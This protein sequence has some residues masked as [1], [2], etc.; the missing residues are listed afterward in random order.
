MTRFIV[1]II[2]VIAM[3]AI[4]SCEMLVDLGILPSK[5]L[6]TS[7]L[8]MLVTAEEYGYNRMMFSTEVLRDHR[9]RDG[10]FAVVYNHNRNDGTTFFSLSRYRINPK[11]GANLNSI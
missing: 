8:E 6:Q 7:H 4:T 11:E 10:R 5:S 3:C 2:A 1:R 9:L